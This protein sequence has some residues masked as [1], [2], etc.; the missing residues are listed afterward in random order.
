MSK[1]RNWL[2]RISGWILDVLPAE[3]EP[4]KKD[5]SKVSSSRQE[6]KSQPRKQQPKPTSREVQVPKSEITKKSWGKF[7][8]KWKELGYDESQF[9]N[10]EEV[11]KI[12]ETLEKGF[13]DDLI[14]S[15]YRLGTNPEACSSLKDILDRGK[16]AVGDDL[17]AVRSFAYIGI[18][19]PAKPSKETSE[20]I[21]KGPTHED[22]QVSIDSDIFVK[23]IQQNQKQIKRQ[24][25]KEAQEREQDLLDTDLRDIGAEYSL[26]SS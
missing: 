25:K 22:N 9:T 18:L 3:K 7:I 4:S 11:L 1:K 16:V 23:K 14:E 12:L 13:K 21:A 20:E 26:N 2:D 6:K 10:E 17:I 24:E 15:L 8:S 5:T 19:I